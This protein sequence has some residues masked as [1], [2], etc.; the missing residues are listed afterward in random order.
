M[1]HNLAESARV[2]LFLRCGCGHHLGS[3]VCVPDVVEPMRPR[4]EGFPP[5]FNQESSERVPESRMGA[6]LILCL[7]Q[8][9][10]PFNPAYPYHK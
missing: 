7:D 9:S 10:K 6:S 2:N 8:H 5:D 4:T 1:D 3:L